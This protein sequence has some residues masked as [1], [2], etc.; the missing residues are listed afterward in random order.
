MD[1]KNIKTQSRLVNEYMHTEFE[2]DYHVGTTL[3]VVFEQMLFHS[4][5]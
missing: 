4:Q 2:N 5:V 1:L 3:I